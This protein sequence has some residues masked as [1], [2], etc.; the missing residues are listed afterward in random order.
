MQEDSDVNDATT[1]CFTPAGTVIVATA[2]GTSVKLVE[3]IGQKLIS[4]TT[5]ILATVVPVWVTAASMVVVR[6]SAR[7]TSLNGVLR[8]NIFKS[9]LAANPPVKIFC[10][11]HRV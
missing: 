4:V 7:T 5:V 9:F 1:S 10:G 3:V 8:L 6:A 2:P 11:G